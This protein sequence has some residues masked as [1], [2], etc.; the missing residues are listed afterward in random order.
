[1]ADVATFDVPL[2]L[3][4]ATARERASAATSGV[5]G[6]FLR[7][8]SSTAHGEVSGKREVR[9]WSLRWEAADKGIAYQLEQLLTLS[10]SGALTLAFTPPDEVDVVSVRFMPGAYSIRQVTPAL[11][12]IECELEEVL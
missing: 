5:R 12:L 4:H 7:R 2:E 3:G 8:Q 10:R 1:M 11:Y 6:P 9:R